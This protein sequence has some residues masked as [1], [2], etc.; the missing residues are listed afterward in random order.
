MIKLGSLG[1]WTGLQHGVFGERYF[2]SSCDLE[3]Y[4]A[5]E[6]RGRPPGLLQP[7]LAFSS[8]EVCSLRMEST[9]MVL[10]TWSDS[11]CSVQNERC[12]SVRQLLYALEIT[13]AFLFC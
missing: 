8:P 12:R 4:P 1:R 2:K 11:T 10:V 5:N 13:R 9:P 3:N 7:V 6:V